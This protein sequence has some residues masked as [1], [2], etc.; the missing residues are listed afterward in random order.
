MDTARKFGVSR[1]TVYEARRKVS[2]YFPEED[3]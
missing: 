1:A 2:K 3:V